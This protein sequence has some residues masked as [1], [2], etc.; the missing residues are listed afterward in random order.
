MSN[1][2]RSSKRKLRIPLKFGDPICE[3]GKSRISKEGVEANNDNGD[4]MKDCAYS[5]NDGKQT[6]KAGSSGSGSVEEFKEYE[7]EYPTLKETVLQSGCVNKESGGKTVNS[8]ECCSEFEEL[9]KETNSNKKEDNIN[10]T[11]DNQMKGIKKTF[12]S[13]VMPDGNGFDNKLELIPTMSEDGRDV[14]FDEEMIMEGS[15]KWKMTLCGHFIGF[16]MS[17]NELHYNIRKMWGK[18]GLIDTVAQN[19]LYYFKFN[20]E[21]GMNQGASRVGYARVLV[22]VNAGNQFKDKVEIIYRSTELMVKCTK[23]VSVEYTW[24]PAKCNFCQVFGHCDRNCKKQGNEG[25]NVEARKENYGNTGA[26]TEK[27]EWV[28][29]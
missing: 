17:Y 5:N 20:N 7:E 25:V 27:R 28:Q 19:G 9:T 22:E 1:K 21:Y 4:E 6:A 13:V 26:M 16:K 11:N 14:V 2:K 10:R 24:K 29:Q 12:A 8:T 23:F 3:L 15:M 18:Y